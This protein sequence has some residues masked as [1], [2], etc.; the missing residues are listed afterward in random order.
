VQEIDGEEALSRVVDADVYDILVDARPKPGDRHQIAVSACLRP[1]N[2]Q[3]L[4]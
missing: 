3:M 2:A 1:Q 4:A